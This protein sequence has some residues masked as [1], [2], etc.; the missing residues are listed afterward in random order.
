MV[1]GYGAAQW[2]VKSRVAEARGNFCQRLQCFVIVIYFAGPAFG[3]RGA[4]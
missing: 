1:G 4:R 3:A 2:K